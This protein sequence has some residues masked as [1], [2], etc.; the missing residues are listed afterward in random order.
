MGLTIHYSNGKAKSLEKVNECLAFVEQVAKS[1]PCEYTVI[2][3]QLTGILIDIPNKKNPQNGKNVTVRQ[4]GIVVILDKGSEPFWCIFNTDTLEFCRHEQYPHD[5]K[6]VHKWGFFTKTQYAKNFLFAH[7]TI[8]RLLETIKKQYVTGL[9][10]EDEGEYFGKW[11][12]AHLQK[13]YEEYSGLISSFG[14]ALDK[15]KITPGDNIE[16]SI[17]KATEGVH[18]DEKLKKLFK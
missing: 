12:N 15:L 6:H 14:K 18:R 1:I 7:T 17:K 10:V 13:V 16:K 11:D 3:E 9:K 8:C 4:K 2:D 5:K